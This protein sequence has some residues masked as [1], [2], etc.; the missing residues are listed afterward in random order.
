M[1]ASIVGEILGMGSDRDMVACLLACLWSG[2][3]FPSH[4]GMERRENGGYGD[5][6][7]INRNNLFLGNRI[8]TGKPYIDDADGL[9]VEINYL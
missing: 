7:I 9:G 8:Y 4:D 3:A 6:V 5:P 1:G 2:P